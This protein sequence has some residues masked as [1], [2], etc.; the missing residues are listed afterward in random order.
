MGDR[1]AKG[2]SI[3]AHFL[4]QRVLTVV[5]GTTY[6]GC[7]LLGE[8]AENMSRLNIDNECRKNKVEELQTV[9]QTKKTSLRRSLSVVMLSELVTPVA[10]CNSEVCENKVSRCAADVTRNVLLNFCS[11]SKQQHSA[12]SDGHLQLISDVSDDDCSFAE[13]PP[14][15]QRLQLNY[16][17]SEF[18]MTNCVSARG[19]ATRQL[20]S[21]DNVAGCRRDKLENC[22]LKQLSQRS[23]NSDSAML[24]ITRRHALMLRTASLLSDD[25]FVFESAKPGASGH[26]TCSTPSADIEKIML[27]DDNGSSSKDVDVFRFSR[28]DVRPKHSVSENDFVEKF[29]SALHVMDKDETFEPISTSESSLPVSEVGQ[30]SNEFVDVDHHVTTDTVATSIDSMTDKSNNVSFE[31][32]SEQLMWSPRHCGNFC[33]ETSIINTP[34]MDLTRNVKNDLQV[35]EFSVTDIDSLSIGSR[36][37][38]RVSTTTSDRSAHIDEV[39]SNSNVSALLFDDPV[40]PAEK[41]VLPLN[42]SENQCNI[43]VTENTD[44]NDCDYSV[45]V[46]D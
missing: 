44:C 35:D 18:A 38:R 31:E 26:K 20:P 29:Q 23:V 21:T 43:S 25:V 46:I 6:R 30:T 2:R 16:V 36:T 33:I 4:T 22:C 1:T 32:F 7:D 28:L 19:L 5:L 15:S 40:S 37:F 10:V 8:L 39:D 14:L 17:Q 24:P 42:V 45:I 13:I 12:D 41:L 9:D 3:V 34:M 11:S 27:K